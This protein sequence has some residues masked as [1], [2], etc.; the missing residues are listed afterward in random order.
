M[1]AGALGAGAAAPAVLLPHV[2]ELLGQLET[3]PGGTAEQLLAR[4]PQMPEM[5]GGQLVADMGRMRFAEPVGDADDDE[6]IADGNS[7]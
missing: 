4:V 5:D 7:H 2:Y 6:L 3:A 1:A